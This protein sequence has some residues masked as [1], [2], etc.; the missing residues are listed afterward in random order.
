L[1]FI[2][3]SYGYIVLFFFGMASALYPVNTLFGAVQLW[4]TP[5]WLKLL[6][7]LSENS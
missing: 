3:I 6:C 5:H 4:L 1:V 2:Y 7:Y